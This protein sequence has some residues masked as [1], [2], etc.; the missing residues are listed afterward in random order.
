MSGNVMK[1]NFAVRLQEAMAICKL[2][3]DTVHT[4]NGWYP[5]KMSC[6]R[7]RLEMSLKGWKGNT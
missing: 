2:F 4:W 6:S 3:D 5:S 1:I 7:A